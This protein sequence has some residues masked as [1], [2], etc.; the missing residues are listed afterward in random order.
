MGTATISPQ[1][2]RKAPKPAPPPK[3]WADLATRKIPPEE[4]ARL[5]A[6]AKKA[7]DAEEALYPGDQGTKGAP[8]ESPTIQ[9]VKSTYEPRGLVNR[10]NECFLNATLQA[11]VS[12]GPLAKVNPNSETETRNLT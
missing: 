3:S 1:P 2:T 10:Q 5:E 7:A 9:A 11:I 8:A 4:K 6:E 12:S